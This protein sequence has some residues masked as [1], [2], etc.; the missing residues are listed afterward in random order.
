MLPI[1]LAMDFIITSAIGTYG[2]IMESLRHQWVHI[3]YAIVFAIVAGII[4]HYV[5]I[6]VVPK[7]KISQETMY[8]KSRTALAKLILPNN[9]EIKITED[10]K[11]FGREDFVGVIPLDDLLVIGRRHFKIVRTDDGVYM[12]DMKSKNGTMLNGEEIRGLGRRKL[13]DGN[14]ILVAKVLRMRYVVES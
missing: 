5:Y 13:G 6:R 11:V 7:S 9:H 3:F 8:V 10:Q 14:E 12:E 2:V 4:M 1:S